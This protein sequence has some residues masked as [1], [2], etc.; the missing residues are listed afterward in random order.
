M[1]RIKK[2]KTPE[3]IVTK[4]DIDEKLMDGGFYF[5]TTHPNDNPGDIVTRDWESI[6]DHEVGDLPFM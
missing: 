3:I 6:T 1:D 4:F 2:Y 5:E